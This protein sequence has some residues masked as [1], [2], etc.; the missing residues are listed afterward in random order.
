MCVY[1]CQYHSFKKFS[2]KYRHNYGSNYRLFIVCLLVISWCTTITPKHCGLEQQSFSHESECHKFRQAS[3]MPIPLF[4]VVTAQRHSYI[5]FQLASP[6][7]ALLACL[8]FYVC[9]W[10]FSLWEAPWAS[11]PPGFQEGSE[12][13]GR[14]RG[15]IQGTSASLCLPR[16]SILPDI[17]K[18]SLST[19]IQIFDEYPHLVISVFP[20]YNYDLNV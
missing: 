19:L 10:L 16:G 12:A 2:C 3:S 13:G 8:L 1:V 9:T 14:G 20:F 17:C 4:L 6:K 7:T 18:Y 5:C 15:R 11:P